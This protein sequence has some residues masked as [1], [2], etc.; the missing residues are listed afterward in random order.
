MRRIYDI[1]C[2][3]L[4]VQAF[5]LE[6][7]I[8]ALFLFIMDSPAESGIRAFPFFQK[9]TDCTN[10]THFLLFT[11]DLS[12]PRKKADALLIIHTFLYGPHELFFQHKFFCLISAEITAQIKECPLDLQQH[13]AN[14]INAM[15]CS[16]SG[17]AIYKR[18]RDPFRI[19]LPAS[20]GQVMALVYDDDTVRK[21]FF[22]FAQEAFTDPL[23]EKII[24]IRDDHL[25]SLGKLN[26]HFIWA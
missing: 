16:F 17:S 4:G 22:Y 2:R 14:V 6:N 5:I 23:I 9:I 15:L 21:I 8:P 18:G 7:D 3:E 1:L 19:H 25:C 11:D 10:E 24:V 20:L 26:C 13:L 12:K